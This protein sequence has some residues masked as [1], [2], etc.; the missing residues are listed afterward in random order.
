MAKCNEDSWF[1]EKVM[2][3]HEAQMMSERTKP[4]HAKDRG[5]D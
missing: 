4:W 5:L 2:E 1:G 3:P